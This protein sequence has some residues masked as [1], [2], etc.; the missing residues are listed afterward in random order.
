MREVPVTVIKYGDDLDQVLEFYGESNH[1]KATLVL[2]HGGYWRDLFDREHMRPLA[3]SLAKEGF[4]VVLPE[5]RRVAGE[6]EVTLRDLAFAISTLEDQAITLIG[7]SS[8][9][10]LALLL[11]DKFPTVKKVIGL[12]PVTDLIESQERELGR[13]AVREWLGRD[14]LDRPELD[15]LRRPPIS[16]KTIFIHGDLDE[17]VPLELTEKYVAAMKS[18]GQEIVLEILPGTSHFEMMN[19]PSPTYTALLRAIN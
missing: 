15:P 18:Y 6:P 7:Y 13:G 10:H 11:A 16:S 8:G 2:I 19:I 17:R 14:A 3:V 1:A 5:F 9:G 12:A 4:T